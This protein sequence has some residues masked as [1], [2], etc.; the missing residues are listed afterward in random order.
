MTKATGT[1]KKVTSKTPTGKEQTATETGSS[2][3]TKPTSQTSTKLS[4]ENEAKQYRKRRQLKPKPMTS[5]IY[6]AGQAMAALIVKTNGSAR[7]DDIRREAYEWA[8][9]MLDDE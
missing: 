2:A 1:S 8:E 4:L 7:M 9:F 5:R 3:S 6:L